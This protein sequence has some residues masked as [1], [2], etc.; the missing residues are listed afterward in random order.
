[1]ILKKFVAFVLI[2]AC[3]R[4]INNKI[5]W[6]DS[7]FFNPSGIYDLPS[8]IQDVMFLTNV[9]DSNIVL[10]DLPHVV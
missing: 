5:N 3:Y 6:S 9:A 8:S 7:R 2:L 10:G 4:Y 1:M